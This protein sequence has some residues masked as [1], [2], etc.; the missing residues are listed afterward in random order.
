ME[1]FVATKRYC[2]APPASADAIQLNSCCMN[3]YLH[4]SRSRLAAFLSLAVSILALLAAITGLSIDRL[5]GDLLDIGSISPLLLSGSLAQDIISIPTAVILAMLSMALLKSPGVKVFVS[6][7][8]LTGYFFY[9]YG[10]YVMQG[11]Y[12]SLYLV[13]LAIFGLSLYSLIWGLTSFKPESVQQVR[14]PNDLRRAVGI[15]LTTIVVMLG[16]LWLIRIS[17]DVARN[18]PGE[19]YAVFI[20]DLCVVFPAFGL[21]AASL[22]RQ[23]PFS[24]FLAGVAL[25]KT[26]SICL[27]VAFGEWF[28]AWHGG[29]SPNNSMITVFGVLSLF[30]LGLLFLY[31][32]RLEAPVGLCNQSKWQ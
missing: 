6:M 15:F 26:L 10:L 7:L 18:T 1:H 2:S 21:I 5:Y 8:G 13:Y 16:P 31:L 24:Y 9:S 25:F 12:T 30:S 23:H 19:I 11:Q 32:Q 14:L 20:L 3:P 27:S 4:A 22:F 28:V 29:F 17:E